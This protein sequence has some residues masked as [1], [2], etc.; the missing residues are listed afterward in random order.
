MLRRRVE[1]CSDRL[2]QDLVCKSAGFGPVHMSTQMSVY[3]SVHMSVHT[4]VHTSVHMPAGFGPKHMSTH[5]YVHM[6][7][8]TPVHM[9]AH[10]S[11]HMMG[12]AHLRDGAVAG[13]PTFLRPRA[14][15]NRQR[16]QRGGACAWT[17]VSMCVPHV[18]RH[19]WKAIAETCQTVQCARHSVGDATV[20]PI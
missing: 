16:A 2:E 18:P 7:V 4:Y 6:S 8:H 19:R 1:R 11:A 5:M 9:P 3:I 20:E 17:C 14:C 10:M 12:W 15:E 13:Q